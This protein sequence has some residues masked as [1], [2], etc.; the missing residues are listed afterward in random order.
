MKAASLRLF[1]NRRTRRS[2]S[3]ANETEKIRAYV[4]TPKKTLSTVYRSKS[5]MSRSTSANAVSIKPRDL[6]GSGEFMTV[7]LVRR[8]EAGINVNLVFTK[9]GNYYLTAYIDLTVKWMKWGNRVRLRRL[10]IQTKFNQGF[11]RKSIELTFCDPPFPEKAVKVYEKYF[12]KTDG[13]LE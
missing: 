10:R 13:F 8:R 5:K 3:L 1:F 7:G 4:N 2:K 12:F 6:P 11:V 9:S